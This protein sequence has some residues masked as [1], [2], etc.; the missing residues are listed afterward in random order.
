[1]TY[2]LHHLRIIKVIDDVFQNVSIRHKSQSTEH[3]YDGNFLPNVRQSGYNPLANGTF[4]YSLDRR[5]YTRNCLHKIQLVNESKNNT[6]W[7]NLQQNTCSQSADTDLS[8]TGHHA[9]PDG[10][11][12]S[13][14]VLQTWPTLSSVS[15]LGVFLGKHIH[16]VSGHLLLSNQDLDKWQNILFWI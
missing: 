16:C 12:G 15:I 4:L 1:M 3:N 2:H 14:G 9:D 5:I 11:G 13:G 6:T 7:L 10:A 8:S